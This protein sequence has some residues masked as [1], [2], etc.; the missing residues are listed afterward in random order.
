MAAFR[1]AL[2]ERELELTRGLCEKLL[3]YGTGR[4]MEPGDRGELDRIVARLQADG[5]GL[6]SLVHLVVQSRLF[7]GRP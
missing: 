6:R 4:L 7:T 3:T 2:G 1:A 5:G